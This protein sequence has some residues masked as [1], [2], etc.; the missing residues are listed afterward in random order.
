MCS[1][2]RLK[3]SL[4]SARYTLLSQ[5]HPSNSIRSRFFRGS[6][7]QWRFNRNKN[8]RRGPNSLPG[9]F[10]HYFTGT[11]FV[12]AI[13]TVD[14]FG[15]IDGSATGSANLLFTDLFRYRGVR[16][17]RIL[18]PFFDFFMIYNN[19]LIVYVHSHQS[20]PNLAVIL[21]NIKATCCHSRESCQ[22]QT[23]NPFESL[24]SARHFCPLNFFFIIYVLLFL[25]VY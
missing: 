11:R 18:F 17:P 25:Y 5:N 22:R 10:I 9:N 15:W 2:S 8:I 6:D 19:I 24:T 7:Y 16:Q 4:R 13:R 21:A 14:Y 23:S 12:A 20:S 3:N 1:G